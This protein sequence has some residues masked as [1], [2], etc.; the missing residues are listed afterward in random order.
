MSCGKF[1]LLDILR[2]SRAMADQK[3]QFLVKLIGLDITPILTTKCM[4]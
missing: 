4:T 3:I 2:Y 1:Y